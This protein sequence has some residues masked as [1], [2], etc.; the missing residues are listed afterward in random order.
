MTLLPVADPDTY[1]IDARHAPQHDD[2]D[3]TTG[4]TPAAT[5]QAAGK[6]PATDGDGGWTFID[7]PTV[8]PYTAAGSILGVLVHNPETA[9]NWSVTSTTGA[10]YNAALAVTFTAPATGKV[11][12]DLDGTHLA[13]ADNTRVHWLL[14][15][16]GSNVAGAIV[17]LTAGT[18]ARRDHATVLVSGLTPGA[19]VALSWA[20]AVGAGATSTLRAGGGDTPG[21]TVGG[22]AVMVV[23]DAPL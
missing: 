19:T 12:V 18:A 7:T 5:G 14:R 17:T 11:L 22:Q 6:L 3:G 20:A 10:D 16:A 21:A 2:L 23:R 8:D 1:R 4:H 13:A 9:D 15:S